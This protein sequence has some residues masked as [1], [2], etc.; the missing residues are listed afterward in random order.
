[1]QWTENYV[2]GEVDMVELWEEA[3][4]AANRLVKGEGENALR[5]SSC[6]LFVFLLVL[7]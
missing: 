5:V 3:A 6:F 7:N 1:M 2:C 4:V